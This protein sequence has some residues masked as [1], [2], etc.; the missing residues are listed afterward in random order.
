VGSR[1]SRR[2]RNPEPR[3]P[4]IAIPPLQIRVDDR[5]T[6]EAG[7]WEIE[8]STVARSGGNTETVK[9]LAVKILLQGR[10]R[11]GAQ[12]SM[13]LLADRVPRKPGRSS[14]RFSNG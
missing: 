11:R 2:K 1:P 4:E 7:E 9:H 8:Q 13:D 5:F 3:P 12:S 10:A 14:T 6:D